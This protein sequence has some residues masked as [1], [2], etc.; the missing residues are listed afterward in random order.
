MGTMIENDQPRA[1]GGVNSERGTVYV[2]EAI[3][4][5]CEYSIDY[6]REFTH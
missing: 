3:M 1:A 2:K 6:K 4:Q 5:T